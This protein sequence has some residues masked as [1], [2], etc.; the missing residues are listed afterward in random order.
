MHQSLKSLLIAVALGA[1]VVA[2]AGTGWSTQDYDLY[3]GDF[4]GDGLTD[5]LYVAKDASHP[6]GIALSDGTGLNTTLQTWGNAYLGIPWSSGQYNIVVA[7]F[8]GDG[9]ADLLLQ[10]KTP[11]DHYLLLTEDGGVGAISQTIANDAV[12]LNWSADQHPLIAGDFNGD[13]KADLLFQSPD[14]KGLNAVVLVDAN[15]QFTAARPDQSWIDGYAGLSWAANEVNVYAADFNG[16]GH[17]DLLVQANPI[18][19]TG[20]GTNQPAQFVPNSNGVVLARSS[21]KI[22]AVEGLQAWSREGFGANWSPLSSAVV[23]GDFNGDGRADVLL[24]GQTAVDTSFLLYGKA[25]GAIFTSATS[26][27]VSGVRSADAYRLLVGQFTQGK[28]NGVYAQSRIAGQPNH[29]AQVSGTGFAVT[30]QDAQLA[31]PTAL[32]AAGLKTSASAIGPIASLVVAPTSAGRTAGQFAVSAMGAATY[33][34]PIWTPPG[35][36]GIEPHLA[37]TYA[38][39][40]PDGN[41]GPGWALSGLSSITRCNKTYAENGGVP[42]RVTLTMTDDFCLDGNRLRVTAGVYGAANSTYQT[43]IA[44]FSNI[45]ALSTAGSGPASFTVQGKD[46]LTYEYGNTADSKAYAN[47]TATPY[48]WMLNRVRDRQGNNLVV[49]YATTSGSVAPSTIQYTQ[50]PNTN[51]VTY[52]YTVSFTYQTRLKTLSKYIAGGGVQE[53]KIL[54][55]VNVQSAGVSVR[56]YKMTYA[57]APTTQRDRVS[58]IQECA[59]SLGT[60]C[61]RATTV[62]YQ[63]G[64]AGVNVAAPTTLPFPAGIGGTVYNDFNGDG[65]PD[66]L[67]NNAGTYYVMLS[68]ASGYS[69]AISTGVTT[70]WAYGDVLGT[71]RDGIVANNASVLWYYSYNGSAFVGAS[72][73]IAAPVGAIFPLLVDTE[74][75]GRANLIVLSGASVILYRNTTAGATPSFSTTPITAYFIVG[76]AVGRSIVANYSSIR[77]FDFDGDGRKDIV[78][79]RRF[80]CGT[81]TEPDICVEQT[82]LISAGTTFVAGEAFADNGGGPITAFANWNTD[83][84]TDVIYSDEVSYNTVFVSPC[85]GS[86]SI[87]I[88]LPIA[89]TVG[90]MDWNGD[91]QADV[92]VANGTTLG[93]YLSTGI[94]A[95]ALTTTTVPYT[96][97]KAY[98]TSDVDGDG[99]EELITPTATSASYYP[100]NGASTPSDLATSIKDGWDVEVK[101]TYVSATQNNYTKGTGAVFP[102]MDFIGPMYV[103]SQAS[104]SDGLGGFFNNTF[105]YY[106]ARINRQGR[107]FEGFYSTQS[108]DSRT[109]T[110]YGNVYYNQ[111]YPYTGTVF[112]RETLQTGGALLAQTVNTFNVKDLTG[113]T[114]TSSTSRCFPYLQEAVS[115]SYELTSGTVPFQTSDSTFAYD[116]Y[117]NPL[118]AS[119]TTTDNDPASPNYN[120]AWT[121]LVTNTYASQSTSTWCLDKPTRTTTQNTVPGPT[122]LTRTVDH[123]VDLTNCRYTSE[124]VEP[125]S[126]TLKAVTNFGYD[127]CGNVNSVGVVGLDS[128]GAIMPTRTTTSSYGTRCTFP[129]SVT[130]ALSQTATT[131][132]NYSYG[133]K[134]S[135]TDP[136]AVSVSWLYD[137]FGRK[138]REN[139]PDLTHSS[140][141]Y[142]DCLTII[143]SPANGTALTDFLRLKVTETRFDSANASITSG[144]T[145]ADGLERARYSAGYRVLGTLTWTKTTYDALGRKDIV[146][147][148]YSAAFNGYHQYTYDLLNRPTFD[149]LF[150]ATPA[151]DRFTQMAYAGLK[152]TITDARSNQT[153]KWTDVTGKLRKII[154]PAPGGTTLYSYD[155]FGNLS[156]ILDAKLPTGATTSYLYNIRGFKTDSTDPD[157]GHWVYTPN[158]LNELMKQVDAKSQQTTFGYDLL[159][160]MTSRVEPE[161][162]T[163]T[164]WVYGTSA[165]AHN[166]GRL[167]TLSKP[168]GYAESYSFDS[169]GRP[170]GT[171]ITEDT[172]YT[173][174]YAYNSLGAVDT[175]TYPASTGSPFVLKYLYS[176]GALQ[177]VKDNAV[178]TVFWALTGA[179]DASLPLT[180][181]LGNGA[182]I[183]SDY[184]KWTNE[185]VKRQVGSTTVVN[186]LQDLAYQWDLN[187]NLSQRKDLKQLLTEDFDHD[188]LNRVTASRL[189]SVTTLSVGYDQAGNITSK[190]DVGAYDYTANQAGCTYQPYLQPHAVRKAGSAVYCYDANGNA[191]SRQGSALA[192][193]SYNLPSSIAFGSNATTFN[194]NASHQRWKQDANYAGVHEIT[195][196]IGG[197]MEKVTKGAATPEYRHLIPAGS[198][199]AI[200][201]RSGTT[202]STY[203]M[204]SD[205]LGS[206]DLVLSS[207]NII[208]PLAKESFTPFGARRGSN[209]Q[210]IPTTADYSVFS[211]VSRRGFTGHEMLD[212]VGL[213][214]MNGRVYDPTIGRFLSADPIIQT[215]AISQAINPFSY[216]MNQPLTLTDPSGLSWL[217]KLFH[218]IGSFL[219]K[220]APTILGIALSFMGVPPFWC[221]FWSSVLS[222]AING[223]TLG[224]FAIGLAVGWA[225]GKLAGPLAEKFGGWLSLTGKGFWQTTIRGAIGGALAGGISSTMMGGSFM[226]GFAAGALG[227][228][229][230]AGLQW[231][232]EHYGAAQYL[233]EMRNGVRLFASNGGAGD[234]Q[235]EPQHSFLERVGH[236]LH[237]FFHAADEM[238]HEALHSMGEFFGMEKSA[239]AE[240]GTRVMAGPLAA[241]VAALDPEAVGA[242]L[243]VVL[244]QNFYACAGGGACSWEDSQ[245]FSGYLSSNPPDIAAARSYLQQHHWTIKTNANGE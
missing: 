110:I 21:S 195:Y 148:P 99:L 95:S 98:Q 210:G 182:L 236:G 213:I 44:N 74:G 203:Y 198:G 117:G 218:S 94:G 138:L 237:T 190:S 103:V 191:T 97:G 186:S 28:G 16:D 243:T 115:K 36:R 204:T 166:I 125:L 235:I 184:T 46:G 106:G 104:Q 144:I 149:R 245:M 69:S 100:H 35:A 49:V 62:T 124:I 65:K 150:N 92:L 2:R 119:T 39:G 232:G 222:T 85:T 164:T 67:Y 240:A 24:Q 51:G 54:A 75:N 139:R 9:K 11:G 34:I 77:S 27:G 82:E 143:C 244:R 13:A 178:G 230:G 90:V 38:S 174:G 162:A 96:A 152:T 30:S 101:P 89:T 157:T 193:T 17:S 63:D 122:S 133:V 42:A 214:H 183:T 233:R 40:S 68:T 158:S 64:A 223:G 154:D 228:A 234:K 20:P 127:L 141:V 57:T 93:A 56:Q 102:E 135:S 155:P 128:S 88:S 188:A 118:T 142:E 242:G 211:T 87:Y 151:Q 8:N 132:Y 126:T 111:A 189:N 159:G 160:R 238:L 200:L 31:A 108:T 220:W 83:A 134:A 168:D 84:C 192:W 131:A 107:G 113:T 215:L 130:N 140:W 71:G 165:A 216:V 185:V 23:T 208:T 180:E 175:V 1:S 116:N 196:Y 10:R 224:S 163:A 205:H 225:A 194:Y 79:R 91:G 43:E 59:G 37:I 219:K 179:N 177:Q 70:P 19:G 52:P 33:Q 18:P 61:L 55:N 199:S 32:S 207:T 81:P 15:G 171:I 176:Y 187:G 73:G 212:S 25:T 156:T 145:F 227:G 173:V 137:N 136:N 41:M 105:W 12:G 209:W 120:G 146:Y 53:T 170:A 50:T 78:G 47:A 6:N 229:I 241:G 114:C 181:M 109:P 206:G 48:A 60:D 129:E 58:A 14:A 197:I 72:L 86:T 66:L 5:M 29:L 167:S 239:A 112:K 226:Q 76:L 169:L 4:N 7:D 231:G 172:A 80:N 153:T 22:F 201:T 161:S 217:S 202:S 221:G 123:V 45:T 147:V 121:S 3:P 26:L